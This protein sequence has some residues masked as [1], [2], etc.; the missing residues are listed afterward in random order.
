MKPLVIILR[1]FGVLGC[2][3]VFVIVMP[4][5]WMAAVHEWLGLGEFPD[6]PITQHLTRSISALYAVFGG[7]AIRIGCHPT[8]VPSKH[9]RTV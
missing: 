1:F 5:R 4:T 3:A 7:L 6:A 2:T 9:R 8:R